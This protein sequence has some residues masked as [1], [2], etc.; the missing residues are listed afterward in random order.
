MAARWCRLVQLSIKFLF[1]IAL[2]PR[3]F[4]L[5][6]CYRRQLANS[7][8]QTVKTAPSSTEVFPKSH[9][10]S[11]VIGINKSTHCQGPGFGYPRACR[12]RKT[13]PINQFRS[14]PL[15][16]F[17]KTW[18]LLY[19]MWLKLAKIDQ[20]WII[21]IF[22]KNLNFNVIKLKLSKMCSTT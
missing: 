4:P 20:K 3:A 12:L 18:F 2:S 1:K 13:K 14:L 17:F 6:S 9:Q 15:P 10:L 16:I 19:K 11:F 5:S 7:T 22:L 21:S 8:C